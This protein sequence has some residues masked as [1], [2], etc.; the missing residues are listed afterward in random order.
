MSFS[1]NDLVQRSERI[2]HPGHHAAHF[3]P[4]AGAMAILGVACHNLSPEIHHEVIFACA[5][6]MPVEHPAIGIVV[7]LV[8]RDRVMGQDY[9]LFIVLSRHTALADQHDCRQ[10]DQCGR[11][12]DA[13]NLLHLTT[14]LSQS[15]FFTFNPFTENEIPVAP[16]GVGRMAG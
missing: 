15:S 4:V 2:V 11:Q 1:L 16:S 14:L 6:Y 10:H 12:Y 7:R 3:D 8:E 9:S 5:L 13:N